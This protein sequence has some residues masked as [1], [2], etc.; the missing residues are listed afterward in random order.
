MTKTIQIPNLND[1]KL[2][3]KNIQPYIHNT[4]L[5]SSSIINEITGAELF[6]KCENFQKAGAFKSRGATNALLHLKDQGISKPVTTHSSGNHAGALAKAAA[7]LGIECIVVMPENAPA[8]KVAAVKQYGAEIRFCTPTLEARE[9]TTEEVISQTGAILIHPYDNF[10]I[11]AGQGTAVLEI[12]EKESD[13]TIIITP[14]GGGGLLSGS[15]ITAKALNP[16]IK[17]Y[18][19]EPQGADDAYRSLKAGKIIP[20]EN[21][22]TIADGLLTSLGILNFEAITKNVDDILTVSE[23]SIVTAMKMIWQYMKIV[24]EPSGAVPLA[25]ILEHPQIFEGE[26]TGLILSGGN[27]DLENLPF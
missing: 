15:S 1:I 8:V 24:V 25:A 26:K 27:V 12:L 11:I 3:A 10:N 5:L 7:T 18:A 22:D 9:Q 14:V 4:P 16:T 6:F 2:A 13:I 20:S 19:G 23:D 21:P 17:V